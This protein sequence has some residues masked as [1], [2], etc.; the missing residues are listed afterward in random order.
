[1]NLTVIIPCRNAVRTIGEQLDALAEQEWDGEWELIVADNGSTDGSRELVESYIRRLPNL[2]WIDASARIGSSFARN[3][4]VRVARA[5][6]IAFCDADDRVGEGWLRAI[7]AALDEHDFVASRFDMERLDPSRILG[8]TQ[9]DR[10]Q[11]LWYSPYLAVAGGGGLGIK[12]S[13]HEEIGGFDEGLPRLMDTDYC[14]RAQLAGFPL[15]FHPEAVVHVRRREAGSALF[16]QARL[17]AFFNTLLY[18]RYRIPSDDAPPRPWRTFVRDCLRLVRLIPQTRDRDR[19][20]WW[21]YKVGWQ[22]GLLQGA[23]RFSVAPLVF[24]KGYGNLE[25]RTLPP[26]AEALLPPASVDVT[27]PTEVSPA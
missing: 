21:L 14:I 20:R 1:M 13:M 11:R 6:S 4:A 17:W 10:L 27:N 16:T 24:T 23:L 22:V 18:L 8:K 2:C 26:R 7:A 25:P 19:R 9:Y 3:A 12:R 15:H 5:E